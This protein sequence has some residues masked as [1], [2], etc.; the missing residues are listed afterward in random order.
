MPGIS[1][2]LRLAS[3]NEPVTVADSACRIRRRAWQEALT[4]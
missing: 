4:A 3:D 2:P 1:A